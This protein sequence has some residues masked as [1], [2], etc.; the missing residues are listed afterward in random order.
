MSK[1][2]QPEDNETAMTLIEHLVEL[3][4]RLIRASIGVVI[5]LGVGIFLVLGPLRLVDV[6]IATF[7]PI[8][9]SYAPSSPSA[10]PSHSPAT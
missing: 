5:G 1:G 4:G 2:K 8:N 7:A 10:P 3:R 6:I 9:H